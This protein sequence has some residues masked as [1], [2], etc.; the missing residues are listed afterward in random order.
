VSRSVFISGG[1]GG[2]GL[3]TARLF[4]G[5]GWRVGVGD[6]PD[7]AAALDEPGIA[8]F[9]HDVRDAAGWEAVLSR[10]CAPDGGGL[11]ALVNN[12]GLLDWGWFEEGDADAYA[13][14]IDVNVT[15]VM[16]G[17]MAGAARLAK[18]KGCLVNLGSAAS[19]SATPRLAVYSATKFAVRGL[20]EALS[21][22]WARTGVRVA[23]VE[24]TVIDTP[25]LD[26]AD[27]G[28]GSFRAALG[29]MTPLATTDVAEAVLRA[30]EGA[31]LHYPVGDMPSLHVQEVLPRLAEQRARWIAGLAGSGG[32]TPA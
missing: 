16:L 19:F 18:R 26:N 28:G 20:S 23:C 8:A 11:D 32:S 14:T 2:I 27:A 21:L 1:A 12:A 30:A 5:R 17:A 3:A 22:E 15:G 10:F 31:T 29:G 7:R 9:A 13:R 6:L 25:M 24:P 4:A